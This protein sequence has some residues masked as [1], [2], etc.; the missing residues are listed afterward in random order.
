[1]ELAPS[2]VARRLIELWSRRADG[3]LDVG[4]RVVHLRAGEVV[5]VEAGPGDPSVADFLVR[6]GHV[7]HAPAGGD[8][9]DALSTAGVAAD[10]LRRARRATWID[11]L[12]AGLALLDAGG[13]TE[14]IR[15]T[16][17]PEGEAEPLVPLLLDALARRAAERD[18]GLVG[19]RAGHRVHLHLELPATAEAQ[20]WAKLDGAD[21]RAPLAKLLVRQPGA[22]TRVAALV[23][24][25]LAVLVAPGEPVPPTRR[26]SSLPPPRT[27][28]VPSLPP[29]RGP[30]LELSP[31][32]ARDLSHDGPLA[33]PI[34]AWPAAGEPLVDPLAAAEA[35]V[36][37]L[38]QTG[39]P[40]PRR[41]EAWAEIAR[42][43]QRGFGALEEACRAQREAAAA[44]PTDSRASRE[45]AALCAA[46][47]RL[48]L[49][50]AYARA[51]RAAAP[52]DQ[53][54]EI[55]SEEADLAR[56]DGDLD[57]AARI[58]DEGLAAGPSP[59]LRARLVRDRLALGAARSGPTEIRAAAL[60]L[61]EAAPERATYLLERLADRGEL[62]DVRAFAESLVDVGLAEAAVA[63]LT[64][65]AAAAEDVDERRLL[66]L[67]AA[68]TAEQSERPD[69]AFDALADAYRDEPYLDVLSEPLIQDAHAAGWPETAAVWAESLGARPEA[70]AS[71]R[72]YWL[73]RAA[74][75]FRAL[76]SGRSWARELLERSL[77]LELD[78][79]ALALVRAEA[80][81]SRDLASL[82]DCLERVAPRH[83]P[84]A[85]PLLEE[86]AE[87]CETRLGSAQRALAAWRTIRAARPDHPRAADELARLEEKAKIKRGLL[88]LAEEDLERDPSPATAR[89]LAAMLRDQPDDRLRAIELYERAFDADPSDRSAALALERL[90]RLRGDHVALRAL[91]DRR[92]SLDETAA[93]ERSR[94]LATLAGLHA[95]AGDL[96]GCAEACLRWLA[97]DGD[98]DSTR[99]E[100]PLAPRAE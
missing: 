21:L 60:A 24:A 78:P 98:E 81:T 3:S 47:G 87:L 13:G 54:A 2:P 8:D 40:G 1:M 85:V 75:G 82:A 6:A 93:G 43:W 65:R 5:R 4:G 10:R 77:E 97:A 62:E 76:L 36:R 72:A 95:L 42:L 50:R 58:L 66:R 74:E 32:L 48:E 67:L 27:A 52:P 61:R 26:I 14:D 73:R 86:L 53:L 18:A 91:L 49:A 29:S 80:E 96:A 25:G 69:L 33:S 59:A 20:S 45:A 99:S 57:E 15:A 55:L 51:A 16:L 100:L 23:R 34:R 41:A 12:V 68:E 11:R 7:T 71:E 17:P 88:Q 39:A 28:L 9:V 19:E 37:Q 89:K 44:D 94:I 30:L 46:T 38:E 64:E 22:A 31:G 84:D 79:E 70:S 92:A 56:R 63:Y 35:R 90:H 83:L